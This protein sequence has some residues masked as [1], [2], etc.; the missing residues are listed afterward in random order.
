MHWKEAETWVICKQISQ[1]TG[2]ALLSTTSFQESMGGEHTQENPQM[3]TKK[4][5]R[6]PQTS[7]SE[8]INLISIK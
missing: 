6:S 1:L 7:M 2:D 4:R 3:L 8:G 5:E